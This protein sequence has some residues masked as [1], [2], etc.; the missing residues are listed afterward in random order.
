MIPHICIFRNA[1]YCFFYVRN[2][3]FHYGIGSVVEQI[4]DASL[5]FEYLG[6]GVTPVACDDDTG[7]RQFPF[8]VL[9]CNEGMSSRVEREGGV[10][11]VQDGECYLIRKGE[12]HRLRVQ[13]GKNPVSIWCHFRITLLHGMDLLDF[14]ELPEKF[15]PPASLLIREACRSLTEGVPESGIRRLLARKHAGLTLVEAIASACPERE[16]VAAKLG[17]LRRLAPALEFMGRHVAGKVRLEEVASRANLS[18]SRFSVLFRQAMGCSPGA[19]CR[20]LR[21]RRAHELLTGGA[22]PAEA[23]AALNFYDVFHF[24]RCFKRHFGVTPAEYLRRRR[25]RTLPF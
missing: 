24:S 2:H 6:G 4:E 3:F 20:A 15:S 11:A 16:D 13:T 5:N 14:F 21:L 23:A 18:A 8:Y 12:V 1:G 17:D 25:E 10:T 7:R 19:Y 22:T 9:V